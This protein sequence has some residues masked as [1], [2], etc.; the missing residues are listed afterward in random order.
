MK[1]IESWTTIDSG[2]ALV[3]CRFLAGEYLNEND[4]QLGFTDWEILYK[5]TLGFPI[6]KI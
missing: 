4:S 2:Y 5:N 1:P 3:W 6:I